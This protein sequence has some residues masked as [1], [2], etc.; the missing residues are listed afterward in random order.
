MEKYIRKFKENAKSKLESDVESV[1]KVQHQILLSKIKKMNDSDA[2]Y[3]LKEYG[4]YFPMM[5]LTI[6][7]MNPPDKVKTYIKKWNKSMLHFK[8]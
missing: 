6:E 1:I 4:D 5:L 7:M 3:V 8:I 2:E